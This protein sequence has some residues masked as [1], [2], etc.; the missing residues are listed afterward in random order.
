MVRAAGQLAVLEAFQHVHHGPIHAGLVGAVRDAAAQ[1]KHDALERAV[2]PGPPHRQDRI[3]LVCRVLI[4]H[5]PTHL[6][7]GAPRGFEGAAVP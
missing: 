4:R 1:G 2:D 7:V 5:Q 3:H 6:A